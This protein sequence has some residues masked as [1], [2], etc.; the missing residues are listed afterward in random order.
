MQVPHIKNGTAVWFSCPIS[1]YI[2]EMKSV[3]WTDTYTL[4]FT[5][6]LF[7]VAKIWKQLKCGWITKVRSTP[8]CV[9]THTHTGTFSLKTEGNCV[10]WNNVDELG[11]HCAKWSKPDREDRYCVLPVYVEPKK[12]KI[13]FR[14]IEWWF[15]VV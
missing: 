11:G 8:V 7:T 1:G 9:C 13:W 12:N 10:I 3:S 5:A 6:A 15:A 2:K 4:M 14:R